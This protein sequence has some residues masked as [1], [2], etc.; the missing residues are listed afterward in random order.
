MIT[1][2]DTWS[3]GTTYRQRRVVIPSASLRMDI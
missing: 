1:F 3:V 2:V